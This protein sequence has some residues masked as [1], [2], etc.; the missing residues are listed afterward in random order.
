MKLRTFEDIVSDTNG[1]ITDFQNCD[2]SDKGFLSKLSDSLQNHYD[3]IS[4]LY[5][6]KLDPEKYKKS[7][8]LLKEQHE[9]TD[10]IDVLEI[11]NQESFGEN[12]ISM[13]AAGHLMNV[14][15]EVAENVY[16]K[17]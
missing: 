14:I 12:D 1:L 2:D 13:R 16:V 17:L 5:G 4:R 9:V 15:Y 8:E 10:L 3:H 6:R 11:V 7:Y